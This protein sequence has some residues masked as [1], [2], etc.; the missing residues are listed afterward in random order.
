MNLSQLA[1]AIGLTS[2]ATE[3][4]AW[5]ADEPWRTVET[6][7]FRIH[8]PLDTEA[9]AL[10]LAGRI[11]PMRERVADIVGWQPDTL[12]EIVVLDPRSAANGFALPLAR[13]ARIGVFPTAPAA[14]S[15]IGNYRLW[16]EDLLVH[17]DAHVVHLSRASRNPME[18][19]LFEGI[20]GIPPIA[21]KSPAW[22]A[23][24]Y[25][26]L[27]EGEL[28]GEGRP[29]SDGRATFLRM[30]A[31]EGQLPDYSQLDGSSRWRGRAMR[32]LVGSAYLEWLASRYGDDKLPELWARMTARERRSF[33][34]AFE[35]SFG[36]PAAE[37]YGRFVAELTAESL[38]VEPADDPSSL[39]MDLSGEIEPPAVSPDGSRIAIVK[40][41]KDG[42]AALVVYETAVDEEAVQKRADKLAEMLE[43][44]PEDVAPADPKAAPHK[45]VARRVHPHQRPYN[46]R[47]IDDK[48]LLY[49]AWASDP[50]GVLQ[51]DLFT[52][53][54]DTSRARRIT[55]HANLRE[56]VPCGGEAVA[57]R[58]QHG[59]SS[60]MLVDLE[61]GDT[62]PLTT[63]SPT[64]VDADPRIDNSCSVVSWLRHDGHWRLMVAPLAELKAGAAGTE[65]PLPEGGQLMSLD[66]SPDGSTL[67]AAIG[68]AG[69][70]DLWQRPATPEGAWTR[71]THLPGGAFAPEQAPDGSVYFL[72]TDPR[73][74]DL[75]HLPSDTPAVTVTPTTGETHGAVRPPP[76]TDAPALPEG[77]APTPT[78]YG[79]GPH[80]V[81][82]VAGGRSAA[83]GDASW[84]GTEL[85]LRI[86]DLIGRSEA[87]LQVGIHGHSPDGDS[88]PP[89]ADQLGARGAWTWR[90]L[91]VHLS[92][93]GWW[94]AFD[95]GATGGGATADLHRRWSGGGLEASAGGFAETL[96]DSGLQ[97]A[98]VADL[99]VSD[100]SYW[101]E[102]SLGWAVFGGAQLG[103]TTRAQGTVQLRA[104]WKQTGIIGSYQ[105]GTA[106]GETLDIRPIQAGIQPDMRTQGVLWW[107]SLPDTV[108]VTDA[109]RV[110]GDMR[111]MGDAL[112]IYGESILS[113]SDGPWTFLGIDYGT[114]MN[115]Q[116]I[117]AVPAI[118]GSAG[119]AC[120]V[121]SPDGIDLKACNS[122]DAWSAWLSVQVVPGRPP[123]SPHRP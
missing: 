116:P 102:S 45:E 8:Y 90:R 20:L 21:I 1:L 113:S 28:T 69:F 2:F 22:V 108:S 123:D 67:T 110:R 35:G 38:A 4:H 75:R 60:L 85:G 68:T 98:A 76:V 87:L 42:P 29:N 105:Q 120:Q 73:G 16:A 97:A 79:L 121:G 82:F 31:R 50:R 93:E 49:S 5:T 109:S 55:R 11:D 64:L 115:A 12:T 43:E 92:A 54:I 13:G 10:D 32:Y 66:V 26:T 86:G 58:R 9:W 80:E 51:P 7:H 19:I 103:G 101:G 25:A 15:G 99:S 18:R 36:A 44:D 117:A 122:A 57:V 40:R 106:L 70:I 52:W 53:D 107:R 71:R 56:A 77:T 59:L 34:E 84:R 65:L 100:R 33:E 91:P 6:E 23:E 63:P 95:G 83:I 94:L 111:F 112:G 104:G 47:F 17:E 72:T 88:E 81:R 89:F 61:S 24:G 14:S 74:F 39:W 3:A 78:A 119:L 96:T 41:E 46:P 118:G 30:L 37:L 27:V 48:T 62:T 114:G